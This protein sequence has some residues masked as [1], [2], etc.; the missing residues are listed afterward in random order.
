MKFHQGV[1]QVKNDQK[2][3]T[4]FI[5]KLLK[6]IGFLDSKINTD[7][8]SKIFIEVNEAFNKKAKDYIKPINSACKFVQKC[9]KNITLCKYYITLSN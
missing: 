5:E 7:S 6:K 3:V 2:Y 1:Y 8:L 9:K 4:D